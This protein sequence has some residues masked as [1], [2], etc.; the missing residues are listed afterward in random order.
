MRTKLFVTT[1]LAAGLMTAGLAQAQGLGGLYF[2]GQ[3]G[4]DSYTTK[5]DTAEVNGKLGGSGIEGGI[6]AGYNLMMDGLLVGA[7]AQFGLSDASVNGSMPGFDYRTSARE[8][9]G[10]S[11]RVGTMITNSTLIYAH[12]GWTKT[13]FKS[14]ATFGDG[15]ETVSDKY[16]LD[17]WRLGGGLEVMV[18]EQVSARAEYSHIRYERED[19]VRPVNNSIQLGLAWHL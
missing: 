8:S 12:T 4:H 19:G 13:R 1:V 17:G 5:V 18:T 3:I 15:I 9:W 7:E 14:E 6:F 10:L 11:G 16:R 2:G